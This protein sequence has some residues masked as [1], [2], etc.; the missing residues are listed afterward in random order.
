MTQLIGEVKWF[1]NVR[2]YGFLGH[3]GGADVFFH[4][5]AIE[6]EGYKT[7]SAGD[8]VCFSIEQGERGAQGACVRRIDL[9]EKRLAGMPPGT[10]EKILSLS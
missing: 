10:P 3:D 7:L 1:N 8:I 9:Q 5:S 4:Y 6:G 2:G